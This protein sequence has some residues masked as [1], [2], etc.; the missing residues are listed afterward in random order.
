LIITDK[1][2]SIIEIE[3]SEVKYLLNKV[4]KVWMKWKKNLTLK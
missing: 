3:N 1:F 2:F 4:N